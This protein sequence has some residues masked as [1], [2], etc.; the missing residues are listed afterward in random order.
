MALV[1]IRHT[2]VAGGEGRC[3]GALDLPLAPEASRDIA[4]VLASVAP[5]ESVTSSPSSRCRRL[6]EALAARDHCPLT[7]EPA[8]RELDFGAWEGRRWDDI[9]RAQSDPWAEDPW[10]RAPPGGESESGLWQRLQAWLARARMPPG[11]RIAIVAHAGPLRLLR[12]HFEGRPLEDR[13]ALT[14]PTGGVAEIHR[15]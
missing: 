6:A 4:V 11:A 12:C 13:W 7:I 14:L 8:L 10:N 2:A 1:L 15:D 3:Y 5:V 9:D